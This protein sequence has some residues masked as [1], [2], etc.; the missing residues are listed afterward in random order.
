[1]A[2]ISLDRLTDGLAD[3]RYTKQAFRRLP[4]LTDGEV[5]IIGAQLIDVSIERAIRFH[6]KHMNSDQLQR[7][8]SYPNSL[9]MF[10]DKIEVGYGLELFDR[11]QY[12]DLKKI[13]KIRNA[14]AHSLL[15]L[16]FNH[17]DIAAVV[18]TFES[19][20]AFYDRNPSGRGILD[21]ANKDIPNSAKGRFAQT[22]R[23]IT[24][25]VWVLR[26]K[27][28]DSA[29][30]YHDGVFPWR[31]KPWPAPIQDQKSVDHTETPEPPPQS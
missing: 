31:E 20:K 23:F 28:P 12:N 13:Q 26:R 10:S 8:F 18:N 24:S 1:M 21:L 29:F 14:F 19:Y 25:T 22:C 17:P 2:S 9:S 11:L 27:I 15:Q 16:T 4:T 6:F 7:I 30:W 3:R 5:A